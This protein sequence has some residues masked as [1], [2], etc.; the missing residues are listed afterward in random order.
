MNI[1]SPKKIVSMSASRPHDRP[2]HVPGAITGMTASPQRPPR[3]PIEWQ[4]APPVQQFPT[5]Q[6]SYPQFPEFS[7]ASANMTPVVPPALPQR[8]CGKCDWEHATQ[9]AGTWM[10]DKVEAPCSEPGASD[11]S[12]L[13]C[14]DYA[15]AA[16]LGELSTETKAKAVAVYAALA[17]AGGGLAYALA[18]N[19]PHRT[20]WTV[21][22]A[23]V[24]PT[25]LTFA[26]YSFVRAWSGR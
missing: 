7:Y 24:G 13:D 9:W 16:G 3:G 5:S 20:A 26:V 2:R 6:P 17:A 18:R 15:G 19:S 4:G 10:V 22:G 23:L 25:A 1:M 11:M 21:G 14:H 12:M 8:V